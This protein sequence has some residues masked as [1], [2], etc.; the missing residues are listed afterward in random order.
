MKVT[1]WVGDTYEG[2]LFDYV[3]AIDILFTVPCESAV[4]HHGVL[5]TIVGVVD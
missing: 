3:D 1:H 2:Y 5:G 4:S